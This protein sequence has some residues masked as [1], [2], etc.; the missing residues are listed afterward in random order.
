VKIKKKLAQFPLFIVQNCSRFIINLKKI[1]LK[2]CSRF[3]ECCRNKNL[4]FSLSLVHRLEVNLLVLLFVIAVMSP[5]WMCTIVGRISPLSSLAVIARRRARVGDRP[6]IKPQTYLT[7]DRR[8][9]GRPDH[10]PTPH[11]NL[12]PPH[13]IQ[14]LITTAKN[15]LK[16]CTLIVFPRL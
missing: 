3:I 5:H 8:P 13:P 12:P 10:L 1:Y 7:A 2:K 4:I 11:H 16:K 6:R 14:A 15:F 9:H